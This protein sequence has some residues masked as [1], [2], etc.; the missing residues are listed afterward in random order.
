M[1]GTHVVKLLRTRQKINKQRTTI[2]AK[3]SSTKSQRRK[4]TKPAW[5]RQVMGYAKTKPLIITG[6]FALAVLAIAS[7]TGAPNGTLVDRTVTT[8]DTCLETPDK[9]ECTVS[10]TPPTTEPAGTSKSPLASPTAKPTHKPRP[11]TP[12]TTPTPTP[13]PP[14]PAPAPAPAPVPTPP[15][16]TKS[17]YL[18]AVSGSYT[19][20]S[21]FTVEV[22]VNALTEQINA[23]QAD[24]SYP[25]NLQLVAV[26]STASAYD[27]KAEETLGSG[28]VTIVRGSTTPLSGD[29]LVTKLT[30]RVMAAGTGTLDVLDSSVVLSYAT[31]TDILDNRQDLTYTLY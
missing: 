22:R 8:N 9:N 23:A 26:D 5:Q 24:I 7:L 17:L 14:A 27:I 21:Q 1:D 12:S 25:S 3:S 18:S 31:H 19:A 20:G 2:A 29:M 11:T 10:A 4:T 30:F 16:A 6:G 13:T 28:S 15:P